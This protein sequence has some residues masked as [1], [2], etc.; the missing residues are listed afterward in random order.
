M[1]DI[2]AAKL[3]E[4]NQVYIAYRFLTS[5]N[6]EKKLK[7]IND[8]KY[9]IERI[10]NGG[11]TMRTIGLIKFDTDNVNVK[12][13]KWVTGDYLK[14]W[15]FQQKIIELIFGENAHIEIIKRCG[16]ILK[17]LAT[18]QCITKEI[19]TM[20]WKCQLGKHEE[21]VRVVFELIKE[22]IAYLR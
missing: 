15:I 21:M 1:N 19:L 11:K 10:E 5:N 9:I 14:D 17:F 18:R 7:G 6:L 3:I 13:M 4:E 8:I 22:F 2:D 16:S 12:P 20:V